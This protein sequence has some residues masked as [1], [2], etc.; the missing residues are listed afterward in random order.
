MTSSAAAAG[1]SPTCDFWVG[2]G[3]RAFGG[4]NRELIDEA[5]MLQSAVVRQRYLGRLMQP[6]LAKPGYLAQLERYGEIHARLYAGIVAQSG[7]GSSSM[8][9]RARRSRWPSLEPPP[10]ICA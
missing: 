8:P 9:A 1:L 10:W 2:V 6:R 3:E 5:V 7:L 4:W